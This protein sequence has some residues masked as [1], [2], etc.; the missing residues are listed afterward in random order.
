M[1]TTLS[2]IEAFYWIARLGSFRAAATQLNLT[3]PTISLRVRNLERSLGARL[4][5]RAGRGMRLTDKGT[6]LLPDV[7]RM[8]DIA[9]E[10]AQTR[11]LGDP[12]HGRLRLGTPTS[13][14]LTCIAPLYAALARRDAGLEIDLKVERSSVLQQRLDERT[15]DLAI[16]IEPQVGPHV[17]AVPLGRMKHAWV[18]S[19]R[20]GLSRRWIEPADLVPHKVLTQPD[21]SNLMTLVLTWF[22]AAGLEPRRI[23]TCD[24]LSVLLRLAVAGEGVAI[25][26]P[27]IL[28]DELGRDALRILRTRPELV[29]PRLYLAYQVD[30]AGRAMSLAIEAVREVV[31][32][33]NLMVSR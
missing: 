20:L 9:G 28:E 33:S 4:F 2:Q 11:G 18:A 15:V 23:G 14:A 19:P 29:R 17:R 12:L 24:N 31:A 27:A 7:R 8:M 22:G 25:L 32:R 5:Q 30:K 16:L 13:V 6:T 26:P 10:L 1:R 21:P 3:Q